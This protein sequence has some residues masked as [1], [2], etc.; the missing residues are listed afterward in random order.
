MSGM[1]YLVATPI[2]NLGDITL[3]A[4]E[5]LKTVD[6]IAAEDTR[7]TLRLLNHYGIKKRLLSYHEHS[8]KGREEELIA[9]LEAGQDVALVCDAGTPL[10]SDPG[11]PLT[12]A[13]AGR[14][15]AMTAIPGPCAGVTAL[16]LS[17]LD[18]QH[19]LF[20]GFL[21]RDRT[22]AAALEEVCRSPHTVVLY[23]S[24]HHLRRTLEDLAARIPDR[25]IAVCRELTK[26]HE[27]VR[28]TSVRQALGELPGEVRGEHVLVLAPCPPPAQEVSEESLDEALLRCRA[29]GLSGRQAASAAAEE[30]GV[31]KNAAYRRLIELEQ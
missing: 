25:A 12:R 10:I 24:P 3:R 16:S 18:A 7:H 22:R 15:L 2:G 11:A 23:E 29:A 14:G 28:R 6:V 17:A 21:P 9:L 19:F 1:L 30:L 27:E 20:W 4:L 8:A 5:T 26:L 13:V 31:S